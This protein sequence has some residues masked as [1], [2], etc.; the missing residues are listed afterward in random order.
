MADPVYYPTLSE[1]AWVETPGKMADMM[2]S[3]FLASNFSQ[4]YNFAGLVSSFPHILATNH[5]DV[6]SIL[7]AT[8][9]I[10]QNFFSRFFE[11]VNVEVNDVSEDPNSSKASIK[12]AV[13][14][15]DSQGKRHSVGELLNTSGT[16]FE[17]VTNYLNYG[18]AT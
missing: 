7:T 12:I 5:G 6:P 11:N 14:F 8:R 3:H 15:T 13:D 17:R 10:L 9:S 18:A 2:M 4:S 16:V 1:E